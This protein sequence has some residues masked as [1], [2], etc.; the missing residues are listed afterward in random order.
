MGHITQEHINNEIRA[1][2]K[3]CKTGAHRNIVAVFNLG[4]FPNTMFYFIDMEL[5]DL[6]LDTYIYQRWTQKLIERIPNFAT[7][8]TTERA[9]QVSR[10]LL[11][12]AN[13]LAFIHGHREVHR[14]LKPQNGRITLNATL[15]MKPVLYS[16]IHDAWKLADFG[17]TMT[18]TSKKLYTTRYARGT[19]SYRAPELVEERSM[20][21]NKVDIWAAG[22]IIF[23]V[24]FRKKAFA[25]D[26]AVQEYASNKAFYKTPFKVPDSIDI[27]LDLGS[28]ASIVQET[29]DTVPSNRPSANE[30]VAR[31][32]ATFG[33]GEGNFLA[34][35]SRPRSNISNT[36][37][38]EAETWLD[39]PPSEV[40]GTIGGTPVRK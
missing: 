18:A 15:L 38:E 9:T 21:N 29:F 40:I 7:A 34:P 2:V 31:F 30:L 6:N 27:P 22:C 14:D 19:S 10:I 24:V 11:D 1:S 37:E 32:D 36:T 25:N 4:N 39:T 16:Y 35:E 28:I 8:T 33:D 26:Y 17:L 5:C 12:I 13:G 3:L 20:F 23:E